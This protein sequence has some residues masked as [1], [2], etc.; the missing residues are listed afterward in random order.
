METDYFTKML[1]LKKDGS[2]IQRMKKK[3]WRRKLNDRQK[4]WKQSEKNHIDKHKEKES[5]LREA[6]VFCTGQGIF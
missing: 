4:V 6:G 3:K 5:F 1:Y 2:W